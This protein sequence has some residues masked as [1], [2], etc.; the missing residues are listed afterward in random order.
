MQART[1][2]FSNG[3]GAGV[4]LP[5]DLDAYLDSILAEGEEFVWGCKS[6]VNLLY[7]FL[8]SVCLLVASYFA[9]K[10][11]WMSFPTADAFCERYEGRKCFGFYWIFGPTLAGLSGF[12]LYV[13]LVNLLISFGF[14]E[15]W[16]VI[17]TSR[18]VRL[19]NWPNLRHG[20]VDY[21]KLPPKRSSLFPNTIKFGGGRFLQR[22]PVAY[23]TLEKGRV[24]HAIYLM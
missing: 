1:L 10:I 4:K 17:T 5:P 15:S 2:L 16:I 14:A 20:A 22:K 18:I 3:R 9:L 19:L 23:Y 24:S 6:G 7:L 11:T 13:L 12:S 8:L 21:Y